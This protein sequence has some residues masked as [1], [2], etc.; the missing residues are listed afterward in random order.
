LESLLG[1]GGGSRPV[2]SVPSASRAVVTLPVGVGAAV[3]VIAVLM[4]G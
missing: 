3:V 2:L 4:L 1:I